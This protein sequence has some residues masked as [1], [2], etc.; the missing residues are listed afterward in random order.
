MTHDHWSSIW[1]E[2][3]NC[4]EKYLTPIINNMIL[5]R[6]LIRFIL[7]IVSSHLIYS[8]IAEVIV[9]VCHFF[10]F[11]FV[12]IRCKFFYRVKHH[13][14]HS[15]DN[16]IWKLVKQLQRRFIN[17]TSSNSFNYWDSFFFSIQKKTF[18]RAISN[19]CLFIFILVRTV[20]IYL[21]HAFSSVIS[22]CF[23]LRKRSYKE[24]WF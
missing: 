16:S 6:N 20:E 4:I 24:I 14:V 15:W 21:Q 12:F 18:L 5:D 17:H 22:L 8:Y 9:Y 19:F 11:F 3:R 2:S 23:V 13:W 1:I 10:C 7:T